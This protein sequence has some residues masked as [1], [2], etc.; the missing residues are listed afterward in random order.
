MKI[1]QFLTLIQFGADAA[2]YDNLALNMWCQACYRINSKLYKNNKIEYLKDKRDILEQLLEAG[3]DIN[4]PSKNIFSFKRQ[5]PIKQC[6][7]Y[8]KRGYT[9]PIVAEELIEM[10]IDKGANAK[11]IGR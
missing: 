3:S 11:H 8:N 9:D 4:E 5:M 1:S 2:K 10:L 6:L 7:D